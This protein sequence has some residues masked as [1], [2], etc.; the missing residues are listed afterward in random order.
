MLYCGMRYVLPI[1]LLLL[2]AACVPAAKDTGR[3]GLRVDVISRYQT[4]TSPAGNWGWQVETRITPASGYAGFALEIESSAGFTVL[5]WFDARGYEW[6]SDL[7][8]GSSGEL[9]R[10]TFYPADADG[11]AGW[12][13]VAFS[14]V[15]PSGWFH[16]HTPAGT[17]TR[18]DRSRSVTLIIDATG[19]ILEV[20]RQ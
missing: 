8:S 3:Q 15:D 1:G 7:Q 4:P 10:L 18:A 20:S 13:V 11:V 17:I 6:L 2:L 14:G 19:A 12:G 16:Q 5:E 9:R